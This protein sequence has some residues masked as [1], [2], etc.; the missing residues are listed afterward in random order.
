MHYLFCLAMS[1]E[2]VANAIRLMFDQLLTNRANEV[3]TPFSS[4][5][6]L[7][8]VIHCLASDLNFLDDDTI[9]SDDPRGHFPKSSQM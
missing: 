8:E 6:P 9:L 5:N 4:D 3:P 1:T 2:E 7:P